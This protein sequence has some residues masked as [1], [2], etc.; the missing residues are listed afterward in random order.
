MFKFIL[1]LVITFSYNIYSQDEAS[2]DVEGF[3]E[4]ESKILKEKISGL[5][6]NGIVDG[7]S[8]KG[9]SGNSVLPPRKKQEI[10][11]ESNCRELFQNEKFYSGFLGIVKHPNLKFLLYLEIGLIIFII[12]LRTWRLSLVTHW[13]GRFSVNTTTTILYWACAAGLI[14]FM[15]LGDSYIDILSGIIEFL[16]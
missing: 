13:L 5:S 12:I 16:K 2:S 1:L 9:L 15:V 11:G 14:P 7:K 6:K 3:N 4:S 8:Q 10:V